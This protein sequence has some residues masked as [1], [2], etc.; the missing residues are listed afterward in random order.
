MTIV[1]VRVC[2]CCW[3]GYI[4]VYNGFILINHPVAHP[5]VPLP[6]LGDFI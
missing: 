5:T 2:T 6:I 4:D 1:Y 3:G